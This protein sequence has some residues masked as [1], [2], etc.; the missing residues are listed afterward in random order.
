MLYPGFSTNFEGIGY[1]L[2]LA[3]R[4]VPA[5]LVA[6]IKPPVYD[7][8][9]TFYFHGTAQFFHSGNDCTQNEWIRNAYSA[10]LPVL[11][12]EVMQTGM[13][14]VLFSRMQRK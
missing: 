5:F 11:L 2:L 1:L 10:I 7:S 3:I 6:L 12:Q 8:C 4:F 9:Q 14:C 13:S